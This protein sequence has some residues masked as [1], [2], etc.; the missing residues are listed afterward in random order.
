MKVAKLYDFT[1]IKI[2]DIP[3]PKIG[4]KEALVKTKACGICSGDVMQWY[5]EKKAPLV[6]GHEPVG[7]I[8][9]LGKG[10]EGLS[11]F[12]FT[13]GDRVF[14]HH[15]APCMACRY[16]NRQDF[17]QCDAWRNSKIVP[18]GI[19]EYFVVPEGN[20]KIDT[21]KLPKELPY[22]DAALIEPV[23]C[24][25]KSLR[26][27]LIKDGDTLLVIG[28]GFMGQVHLMLGKNFGAEKIIGT[29]RISY[30]LIK[31]VES[32][33]DE[34]IDASKFEIREKL[35]ELTDGYMANVV[36]VCPNSIEAIQQGLQCVARGGTLMLFAPAKPGEIFTIDPN[37]IYFKDINITTSYSCGPEDTKEALRL[38]ERGIVEPKKLITHKFSIDE[39]DRAF[40]LT[41]KAGNSLKCMVIFD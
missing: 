20:L 11:D 12:Q 13:V 31:G 40:R 21:L 32:G 22:I 27:S 29:D 4:N 7:E 8:V 35:A 14:V 39:T 28:L 26:R 2:E 33:A 41:A 38:I 6:L 19:S 23:A 36:I 16:C 25:V 5:I 1:T 34:V 18:G 9:E 15:H 37:Y 17:V 30:R 24:V 3:I 10:L